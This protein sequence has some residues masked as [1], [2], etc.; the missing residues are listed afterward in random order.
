[1]NRF[2]SRCRFPSLL[3]VIDRML[4]SL[5]R[6]RDQLVS[7]R[8]LSKHRSLRA[9]SRASPVANLWKENKLHELE[10]ALHDPDRGHRLRGR[11]SSAEA[12]CRHDSPNTCRSCARQSLTVRRAEKAGKIVSVTPSIAAP[13]HRSETA[14]PQDNRRRVSSSTLGATCAAISSTSSAPAAVKNLLTDRKLDFSIV[15]C[16]FRF[17][18]RRGSL[19]LAPGSFFRNPLGPGHVSVLDC[20]IQ[21]QC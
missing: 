10:L 14:P 8:V 12:S 15:S 16:S 11:Y 18:T 3:K 9:L 21:D 6:L 20:P 5:Q 7:R 13:S 1:M 17:C 4:P 19:R 2:R